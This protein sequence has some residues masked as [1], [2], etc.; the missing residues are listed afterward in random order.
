MAEDAFDA[1]VAEA[2]ARL[3]YDEAADAADDAR[4]ASDESRWF[5]DAQLV[6][7]KRTLGRVDYNALNSGDFDDDE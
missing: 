1:E 5:R 7:R 2:E 3:G 4:A 6:G